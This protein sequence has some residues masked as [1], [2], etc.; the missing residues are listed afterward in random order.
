MLVSGEQKR[1]LRL[2]R[3]LRSSFLN[4]NNYIQALDN[5]KSYSY[6]PIMDENL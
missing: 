5:E 1:I 3:I 4:A 2:K 6:L